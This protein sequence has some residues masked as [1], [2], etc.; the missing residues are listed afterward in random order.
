MDEIKQRQRASERFQDG[1]SAEAICASLGRSRSWLY[2]WLRR[3]ETAGNEWAQSLSRRPHASPRQ[4]APDREQQILA[5]RQTL[6]RERRFYGAQAIAWEMADRGLPTVPV[7]TIDHVLKRHGQIATPAR[8][9]VSKGKPYPAPPARH[10]NALHQIDLVGPRHLRGPVR[11][12]SLHAVDR[13][14]GR[15]AVQPLYARAAQD[16]LDALWAIWQRLGIPS[17]LQADNESTFLGGTLH[18]RVLGC[19]VRLCLEHRVQ[20][21]FIPLAEPWRNGVVERF[22]NQYQQKFLHRV[23]MESR[24]DLER[25]SLAMETR[26]NR[27]WRYSKLGGLTPLQCLE[28]SG[29]ALRFPATERAPRHPL[30]KPRRGRFHFLRLIRS[31]L[32]LPVLNETFPMPAHL[33]HEYVRATI[34]VKEQRLFVFH[35][36]R[37]VKQFPY[38]LR[39]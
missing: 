20:P 32:L 27:S 12:Y 38:R 18:P 6:V 9:Y 13:F 36:R 17:A 19:L 3:E 24:A 10:P 31:D 2:K 21:Y 29:A 22:N 34:D 8:R 16:V 26:H 33:A 5:I 39:D 1:E 7:R 15:V 4:T 14:T 37:L 28:N 25:E 35:E 30:P 23:A 11:F